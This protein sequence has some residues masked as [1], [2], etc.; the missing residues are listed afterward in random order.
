MNIEV[1]YNYLTGTIP[2]SWWSM[3]N[4]G[5]LNV[6]GNLLT[7]RISPLVGG[8]SSLQGFYTFDNLM[9][10]PLPTELGKLKNLSALL[11]L[12]D[13]SLLRFRSCQHDYIA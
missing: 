1:L 5:G 9:T 13:S 7:G 11:V 3:E 6:A 8:L 12:F 4:L 10:G 2:D